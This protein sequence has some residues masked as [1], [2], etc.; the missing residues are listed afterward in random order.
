[1]IEL[2]ISKKELQKKI[3][4]KRIKK[5]TARKIYYMKNYYLNDIN[6]INLFCGF[7]D[8]IQTYLV[9]DTIKTYMIIFDVQIDK[10]LDDQK[11]DSFYNEIKILSQ[12]FIRYPSIFKEIFMYILTRESKIKFLEKYSDEQM[13]YI[14]SPDITDSKLIAVPG[15]GKTRSIIGRIKFMVEHNLAKK[16][17]VFAITF[18]RFAS[19][20]FH[21]RI[22]T[23]FPDFDSYLQIKNF[24]TIDSLAK[25][26]LCRVKSHKSE[27]V[28][29]LS[30]AFRNF[31]REMT[32]SEL[33]QIPKLNQI[34]H[35]F[36]DEAQ[37]LNEVQYDIALILKEKC[38][39]HIHL[40]G[41]PNQNIY[42]FRRASDK[43]LSGFNARE[44]YLTK[45]FRSSQQIIDFFQDLRPVPTGRIV[46]ATGKIGPKV[47]VITKSSQDIH[48]LILQFIKLY[49]K[50]KDLSDVAIICP[51]RGI[52]AF[53]SIGLSV[54]F[55]LFKTH[56][57][58][59]NQ[60]Y[61]ES[62]F[63]DER[64]K[65]VNRI[66]GHINLLT[67]H[68]TKG[69]E[70]DVV[71]VMDFY[72]HF[73]NIKPTHEEHNIHRYLLYVACSRAKSL[74]YVCTYTNMHNGFLNHWISKINP[75]AYS[76][77][78]S[79]KIPVLSFQK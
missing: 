5:L 6:S 32:E 64:K 16:E 14:T 22:E 30:I 20:D 62:G 23:L 13:K 15:S 75:N 25:S 44:F 67:Y 49:Q 7:C 46:S 35:L 79:L 60:L 51:T 21:S 17:E 68:G 18:S 42:Q 36:V 56:K 54:F 57:I 26:I 1:M 78:S 48:R 66:P 69:L 29:I 43:Y 41:D 33:Q 31:L 24:S 71:F 73:F 50:E 3:N 76:S 37:D 38:G 40:I 72:Q 19:Q 58:P 47:N 10:L 2:E 77:Q 59:F 8:R 4:K 45:N 9:D 63:N 74:M 52:G 39:T 27:N 53:D 34:K 28:E 12:K 55:N 61:D 11:T 70:F 65:D